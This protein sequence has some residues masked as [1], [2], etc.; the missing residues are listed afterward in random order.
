MSEKD[1]KGKPQ[2]THNEGTK[3][4]DQKGENKP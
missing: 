2:G 1:K 4:S 3:G